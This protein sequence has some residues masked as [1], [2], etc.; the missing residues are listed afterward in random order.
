MVQVTENHPHGNKQRLCLSYTIAADAWWQKDPTC[1]T[2]RHMCKFIC[3]YPFRLKTDFFLCLY[4]FP[5]CIS[6]CDK[7]YVFI[8]RAILGNVI[9]FCSMIADNTYHLYL[10]PNHNVSQEKYISL[11]FFSYAVNCYHSD[12]SNLICFCLSF[13]NHTLGMKTTHLIY[14]SIPVYFILT[15]HCNRGLC[16]IVR[17]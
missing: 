2:Y 11:S 17:I 6:L 9:V 10:F 1:T 8:F 5:S 13:V 4:V 16:V 14:L 12:W 15:Y 3:L 7:A